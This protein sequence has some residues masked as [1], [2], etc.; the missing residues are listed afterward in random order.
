M[1]HDD[2]TIL[3]WRALG[4]RHGHGLWFL[5]AFG[6]PT[7]GVVELDTDESGTTLNYTILIRWLPFLCMLLCCGA[8]AIGLSNTFD[9]SPTPDRNEVF[10]SLG[11]LIPMYCLM[12][13]ASGWQARCVGNSVREQLAKCSSG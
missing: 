12:I 2:K 7:M 6:V 3:V 11:T 9:L 10:M 4:D 8:G 5:P 1:W 13:W